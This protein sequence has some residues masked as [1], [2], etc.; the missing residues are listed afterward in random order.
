MKKMILIFAA[1]LLISSSVSPMAIASTGVQTASSELQGGFKDVKSTHWAKTAIE[2]AV[3]KRY[4]GGYTD[5]T[6]KPDQNVSRSEFFRMLADALKIEHAEKG[7]PWYQPYVDALVKSGIHIESEF[8]G[9]A[10]DL[11]RME[12][13]RLAVR[14]TNEKFLNAEYTKDS[15]LMVYEATKA[16][17]LNGVSVGNL[18]LDGTTTRAQAVA[19]IERILSIKSGKTLNSD[20]YAVAAAEI[21]WHKTNVFTVMP[22]YF[23]ADLNPTY[24]WLSD[25]KANDKKTITIKDRLTI[26]NDNFSAEIKEILAI[27]LADPKDPNRKLLPALD[28]MQ[29]QFGYKNPMPKDAYVLIAKYHVNYNKKP[30]TYVGTLQFDI[31]GFEGD[32]NEVIDSRKLLMS[33]SFLSNDPK[34]EH[35][36]ELGVD[37]DGNGIIV[38]VFPGSGYKLKKDDFLTINV[39]ASGYIGSSINDYLSK[40]ILRVN[41]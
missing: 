23:N 11:S 35:L 27:N 39:I 31:R 10:A 24:G 32:V 13:S 20:K 2:Q 36:N 30:K 21:L 37:K 15:N 17:I 1:M 40:Q 16:G 34:Y 19:I 22:Q 9:Y 41:V 28:K 8:S 38:K 5:G 3:S 26:E 12:L 29:F 14:A 18:A 6:F 25:M 33:S 4:V 7:S